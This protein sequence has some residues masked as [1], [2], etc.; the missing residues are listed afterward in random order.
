MCGVTRKEANHW[1]M[2]DTTSKTAL[3]AH[4]DE[5]TA[6]Q[7]EYHLCGSGCLQKALSRKLSEWG[8]NV[9]EDEACSTK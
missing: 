6:E 9:M 8:A 7:M 5:V 2:F 3:I 4:W 1:L